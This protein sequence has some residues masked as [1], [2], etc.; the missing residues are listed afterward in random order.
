MSKSE[1]LEVQPVVRQALL[2]FFEFP[3]PRHK[4]EMISPLRSKQPSRA[5]VQEERSSRAPFSNTGAKSSYSGDI[6]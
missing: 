2:L 1:S 4:R 6:L 5:M 3:P